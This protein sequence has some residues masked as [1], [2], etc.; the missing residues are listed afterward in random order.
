M[1]LARIVLMAL[2][3]GAIDPALAAPAFSQPREE[4]VPDTV[5]ESYRQAIERTGTDREKALLHK[6][7][8]DAFS[9]RGDI[10]HAGEEYAKA[11]S[12]YRG[13]PPGDRLMMA[14]YLSWSDRIDEAIGELR[15]ILAEDPDNV[16]ARLHLARCLA[17]KGRLQESLEEADMV[18]AASPGNRDA[19]LVKANTLKWAG[20]RN[21][22]VSIYKDL[23]EREEDFD[24]RLGLSQAYLSAGFLRGAREGAERLKPVYPYQ[25]TEAGNLRA[26]IH[27]ATSPAADAS[28]SY[29]DDSDDNRLYRYSMS[30]AFWAGN[31]KIDLGLRHTE[32]RDSSRDARDEDLSLNAYSRV[33]EKIG[34]GGGIGWNQTGN[35]DSSTFLEGRLQADADLGQGSFGMSAARE[36]FAETA[37]LIEN[38]IRITSLSSVFQY[39]L[40]LRFLL[41]LSHSYKDYSDENHSN[42]WQGFLIHTFDGKNPVIA[43]GYRLRFLDFHRETGSGYFD[44]SDFLSHQIGFTFSMEHAQWYFYLEPFF[45]HQSFKHQGSEHNDW[46]WGG[47]GKV[48]TRLSEK[49]SLEASGEGGNYAAGTAAGFNYYMVGLRLRVAF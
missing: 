35:G 8:G 10:P 18:L 16:D 45:G 36:I 5:V 23:L 37:Q 2:M 48:G 20:Y 19:L 49:M 4:G 31:W 42:D 15:M 47:S 46:I 33:T 29:Y 41:R 1:W 30:T 22:A 34:L 11:L 43:M 14:R 32:A 13:F 44:P 9:S 21:A 24:T 28:S 39:P 38:R 3:I 12:L 27:R 26:D 17:W 25:D 6:E 40:P 7:L